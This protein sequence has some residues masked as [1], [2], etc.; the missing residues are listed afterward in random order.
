MLESPV[1]FIQ[2]ET[3]SELYVDVIR[4]LVDHGRLAS[5]RGLPTIEIHPAHLILENPRCRYLQVTKR[6]INPAYAVADAVWVLSGSDDAWIFLF[7]KNLRRFSDDG[8][9]KGAYGPRIRRWQGHLDQIDTVRQLLIEQPD[10]RRATVQIFDPTSD[11]LGYKD[12]A[13]TISHHFLLRE[14]CLDMYTTMRSQDVWLGMPYDVFTNTLLHEL[15]A[16]WVGAEIGTYHHRVDSLHLYV[17]DLVEARSVR[18]EEHDIEDVP[19]VFQIEWTSFDPMLRALTNGEN[20]DYGGWQKFGLIMRSYR[21]WKVG[22][23]H[24]ARELADDIPGWLGRSLRQWYVDHS[25]FLQ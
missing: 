9:L 15:M 24:L 7:N 1:L 13:C 5:P 22:E 16:G 8:V 12:V 20:V 3:L 23:L 21:L 6:N 11:L 19:D 25:H 17:Q 10:T 14:G 2:R 18:L 4:Y